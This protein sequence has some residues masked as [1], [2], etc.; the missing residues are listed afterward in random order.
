L[1][2]TTYAC[3]KAD[4][5]VDKSIKSSENTVANAQAT[6]P[7][8]KVK[9]TGDTPEFLPP[10]QLAQYTMNIGCNTPASQFYNF[11]YPNN[12]N[13]TVVGLLFTPGSLIDWNTSGRKMIMRIFPNYTDNG[14]ACDSDD[15][16]GPINAATYDIKALYKIGNWVYFPL[17]GSGNGGG[18]LKSGLAWGN[19]PATNKKY[20]CFIYDDQPNRCWGTS[21]FY[22]LSYRICNGD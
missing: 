6:K 15:S 19:S 5:L 2:A 10:P 8:P 1:A 20:V 4:A 13:A 9:N 3:T 14:T 16:F 18:Y 21:I 12:Q 7:L 17:N 22:R 11:C